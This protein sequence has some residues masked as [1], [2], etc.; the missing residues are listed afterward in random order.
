VQEEIGRRITEKLRLRLSGEEQRQLTRR[1]TE[2][3]EVYQLYLQGL[4][5]R[6]KPTQIGLHKAIDY[7]QLAIAKDPNFAPAYTDLA[8]CYVL[9]GGEEG[10]GKL[11][12]PAK[13]AVLRALDIDNNLAEA[14]A[15]LAFIKWVYELDWAG[16]ESEVKQALK[17]NPNSAE[18]HYTYARLLA[19]AG[20]FD[21]AR[22]QIRISIELDPLSIQT[23]KRVPYI[24]FL[25]RRYDEAIAEYR[26]LIDLAPDFMP[27]QRELGLA[28]EQKGMYQEALGQFQKA[29][30]MPENYARTLIRAD[31]GHLY[32]VWGKREEARQVLAELITKS[33]RSYVSAYDIGVIYAGLEETEQALRWLDKA[34]EQRPFWLVWLK[35]DPRLDGLRSD[36]RFQDLLRKI[37]FPP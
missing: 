4:Y 14:H 17:L 37:G 22:E 6:S 32:A 1:Y 10:P 12:P 35:L 9:L 7:F 34:I 21:E 20:R 16:A 27:A 5:L 26:K 11:L 36:P 2:N 15:S 33:E 3:V 25:S 31:I 29:S 19:D 13:A 24:L 23:R 8:N 18:A 30:E 28:Y